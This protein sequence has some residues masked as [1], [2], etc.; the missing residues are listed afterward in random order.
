MH[1]VNNA[2]IT[3]SCQVSFLLMLRPSFL[4]GKSLYGHRGPSLEPQEDLSGGID[5]KGG[6][7]SGMMERSNISHDMDIIIKQ[8]V[9]GLEFDTLQSNRIS[10]DSR[11]DL[12]RL[13]SDHMNSVDS[14]TYL[15]GPQATPVASPSPQSLC[16]P[17]MSLPL[18]Q[19]QPQ[20]LLPQ[21][22]SHMMLPGQS[23]MQMGRRDFQG[24]PAPLTDLE[25][26]RQTASILYDDIISGFGEN[27]SRLR[28]PFQL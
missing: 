25:Q 19:Q 2:S 17:Q 18:H 8:E 5:S 23:R 24:E 13:S 11:G 28:I 16:S 26:A 14:T 1:S 6:M 7:S 3:A 22:S 12:H 4:T 10:A 21:D 9:E 27:I 20:D 15:Q